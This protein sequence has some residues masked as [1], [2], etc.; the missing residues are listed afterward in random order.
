M[1]FSWK[2]LLR[3]IANAIIGPL[4]SLVFILLLWVFYK[5]VEIYHKVALREVSNKL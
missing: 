1:D 4:W 3:T 2:K 5:K